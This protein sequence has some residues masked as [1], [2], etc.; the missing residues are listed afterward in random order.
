MLKKE[1]SDVLRHNFFFILF[2]LLL[3]AFLVVTRIL[4]NQSY[5]S[6]FFPLFQFG[7]LFWAF[8]M[9]TSLFSVERGQRGMEYLLSLPLSR[10]KLIGLKILPRFIAILI[11]YLIFLI[12]YLGEGSN[13][14]AL[15]L[16]SFTTVYF[17]FY[18]I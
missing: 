7:L 16:V 1:I 5:Y 17:S 2:I 11:F 4:P 9:G 15:S 10:Y 6:V 18:L 3:P 8:F 14:A 13:Y 12:L